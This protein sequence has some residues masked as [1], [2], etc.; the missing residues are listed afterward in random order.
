VNEPVLVAVLASKLLE[1]LRKQCHLVFLL[2]I[3][4]HGLDCLAFFSSQ[5]YRAEV[6]GTNGCESAAVAPEGRANGIADEIVGHGVSV[7]P[8]AQ[9]A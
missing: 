9:V 7:S 5:P 8:I 2:P 1:A 6:V 3:E 4:I